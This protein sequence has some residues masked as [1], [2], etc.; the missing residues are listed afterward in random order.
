[1]AT[2]PWETFAA[3]QPEQSEP[4]AGPWSKFATPT[5]ATAGPWEQFATPEPT[6][7]SQSVWRQVADVPLHVATG[8]TQGVRMVADAFGADNPVSQ[9]LRG[10]EDYI[11]ALY[12][13][14]S[15]KD[16]KAV[17]RI[18][19]EAQDKGVGDQVKAAA[20]AFAEAPIDLLSQVLGNAAPT[21]AGGLATYL[22]RGGAAAAT[23]VGAG[24][25]A[26]MG[27]GAVK[28]S[29]YDATKQILKEQTNMSPEQ[30]EKR[31]SLA[32]A[33]DGKNLDMILAGT[34]LGGLS[35]A[36]GLEPMLARQAASRIVGTGAGKLL[37]REALVAAEKKAARE[38]AK[39]GATKQ[40]ART[41]A[42]EAGTEFAQEGQEQLAQN[43]A[44]QREGFNVPTGRGVVGAGTL[45]ALSAIGPGG[46]AGARAAQQ[47]GKQTQ[48]EGTP[49]GQRLQE[50]DALV[51]Q[52]EKQQRIAEIQ[53]KPAPTKREQTELTALQESVAATPEPTTQTQT[54]TQTQTRAPAAPA[55]DELTS[56][57]RQLAEVTAKMEQ[58]EQ[59]YGEPFEETI[60]DYMNLQA[61]VKEKSKEVETDAEREARLERAAIEAGAIDISPLEGPEAP[62]VFGP[63]PTTKMPE[64]QAPA[65]SI[66][67]PEVAKQSPFDAI[68][69]EDRARVQDNVDDYIASGFTPEESISYAL[70]DYKSDKEIEAEY[71]AEEEAKRREAEAKAQEEEYARK[72]AEQEAK[73]EK[74]RQ[75]ATANFNGALD[76]APGS[77]YNGDYDAAFEAYRQ[78]LFDTLGEE[79]MLK[80]EDHDFIVNTADREFDRLVAE[81]KAQQP[82]E[83]KPALQVVR[84]SDGTYGLNWLDKNNQ[85]AVERTFKT[86]AE[87]R[88]VAERNFAGEPVAEGVQGEPTSALEP[89]ANP[90][91]VNKQISDSGISGSNGD[92]AEHIREEWFDP[93]TGAL[94]PEYNYYAGTPSGR[95][96]TPHRDL[97]RINNLDDVAK[98]EAAGLSFFITEKPQERTADEIHSEIRALEEKQQGMLS[99]SGRMPAKGTK[100]RAEWD[101]LTDQISD[102]KGEWAE[103]TRTSAP[104]ALFAENNVVDMTERRELQLEEQETQSILEGMAA[105]RRRNDL[106]DLNDK[107]YPF[108]M[109]VTQMADKV[110][111]LE[112]IPGVMVGVPTT[113][114]LRMYEDLAYNA[115]WGV[116]GDTDPKASPFRSP[117][118][119]PLAATSVQNAM[120]ILAN[121]SADI[122]A[123][124]K[125]YMDKATRFRDTLR[126]R[127]PREKKT[128]LA[129]DAILNNV[130]PLES[131]KYSGPTG[132]NNTGIHPDVAAAIENNDINGALR[133]MAQNTSGFTREL[134]ARLAELNLP[135]NIV[136]G[137]QRT[138][139]RKEI[140]RQ[141][142]QQQVRLFMYISQVHPDLYAKYFKNFDREE[143]LEQVLEGL[144]EFNKPKYNKDAIEGE[145]RAV[146]KVF[147]DTVPNMD[148]PGFFLPAFD[149]INLNPHPY[150]GTANRVVLHEIVH[151]ATEY[152]LRSTEGLSDRQKEAVAELHAMYAYAKERI[153]TDEYGLRTI[154]EFVAELMTN[155]GFQAK[156]K[157]IPYKAQKASV[158]T[159]IVN[160]IGKIL[161]FDNLGGAAAVEVNEILSPKRREA[162]IPLGPLFAPKGPQ[163]KMWGPIS[164]PDNWR[165]AERDGETLRE[166][167]SNL[168]TNG[169]TKA[170]AITDLKDVIWDVTSDSARKLVLPFLQLRQ[171]KDMVRTKF[172][173]MEAAVGIV[174]QMIAFR[175]NKI[176]GPINGDANKSP[177]GITKRWSEAQAKAPAQSMLMGRLMIEATTRGIE[178]DPKGAKYNPNK[179][180]KALQDAWDTLTPE[181][182][183]IY[184]D[185][186]DFYARSVQDMVQAMKDKTKGLPDAERAK[187]LKQIDEQFG[188]DKLVAPYFPLRRF[189]EYW[190]QVGEGDSKEFYMFES[191]AERRRALNARRRELRG[192]TKKE[193]ALADTLYAGK[194]ISDIYSHNANTTTVLGDINKMVDN[195]T[196][197][198]PAKLKGEIKDSINQLVYLLL[199]QQSMRK[200][201]INRRSVQGA[202]ADMLRVFAMTSVHSA[203]QQARFKFAEPFL[204][205]ITNADK[206]VDEL[207]VEQQIVYRDF[208]RELEKRAQ[209]VLGVEDKSV[210]AQTVGRLTETTFFFM[211]TAPAS[212]ILNIVGMH[213]ITMP[214]IGGKYGYKETNELMLKNVGRYMAT[215]PKRTFGPLRQ[216]AF[217]QVEFPSIT[218]SKD[219]DPIERRAAD[220]FI[221]NGQLNISTTHD[222]FNMSEQPSA[223]Y[224]GRMGKLKQGLAAMFHQ[225]ERLNREVTLMSTFK[226]S[227]DQHLGAPKKDI[228]GVIERTADG[229]PVTYSEEEAFNIAIDEANDIAGLTLGDYS[230]QMKGRVFTVPGVNLLLQFKQYAITTTYAILR[231]LYLSI[232]APFT[233]SEVDQFRTE[234]QKDKDLSEK[235]IEQR[236]FEMEEQRKAMYKEGRRRLAGVLGMAF[237][238]GGITAMPFFSMLG[239]IVGMFSDDDDDDEYSNWQNTFYNG[240]ED[241]FGGAVAKMYLESGGDPQ[242]VANADA[243]GRAMAHAI[244]RGAA[245]TITGAS[246]A[247]RVSLDLKNLWFREGKFSPDARESLKEDIIANLGP[248]LGLAFN[249]TD[250]LKLIN[251]GQVQRALETIAP[252]VIGKPMTAFRLGT[253]GAT[254]KKGVVMGHMYADEFNAWELALEAMG[255]QTEERA[256][257]GKAAFQAVEYQTKVQARHDELMN[258]IWFDIKFGSDTLPDSL[259][260]A[261]EFSAKYPGKAIT[262]K[263][264]MDAVTSRSQSDAEAEALG[265]RLDKKLLYKTLPMLRD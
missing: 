47:A 192:G 65:E 153:T 182:Q 167:I 103:L 250:A 202:S 23:A 168:V 50:L 249:A 19:Q 205:N 263:D 221:Q 110:R 34:A 11:G 122:E 92:S 88:A 100:K 56:L 239:P 200:M 195:L 33:Y 209:T 84:Y 80:G 188:P 54:Q 101:A 102:K 163:N 78:N 64:E 95:F 214:Y 234:L 27:A 190:F 123:T 157:A 24:T 211:L 132:K 72:E 121:E 165:I 161:G 104:G 137:Q 179:V 203:Y 238:Y 197:A 71:A 117:E 49:E 20:L 171:M 187:L 48:F 196:T 230:R 12:S 109:R 141:T 85:P 218:E 7:E 152:A 131:V 98:A 108:L 133:A 79:G 39:R 130:V 264:V 126:T 248:A 229:K 169:P 45:G 231:N 128:K 183:Q 17:N 106:Q 42:A 1:M 67:A 74:V 62:D 138:L 164:T 154:Y 178:V 91:R 89:V 139:L 35:A 155:K 59:R 233:K 134:A 265:A 150:F 13:A 225:A 189:G 158:W 145:F 14:Q 114:A 90:E 53:Q 125:Q 148:A 227:Y 28:G 181:F 198:D 38:M 136:F 180:N 146:L 127:S 26:T 149:V 143:N 107:V 235:E 69:E 166:R 37:E 194:G 186:R 97:R 240:M 237:L 73:K 257:R 10:V 210:W 156:L 243:V 116:N 57:K 222:V 251:E 58:Q 246:I 185:A 142:A 191:A 224:T 159:R 170:D 93:K 21:I 215:A 99:K 81:H 177:E 25:G 135:T 219:L 115:Y 242:K 76:T 41:A 241:A 232:G 184:R 111:R 245:S 247:D 77:D 18:M 140:D 51:A 207:P 175:G 193:Q 112:Q 208:V 216:G 30:I 16:A 70:E 32:Q 256:M 223:M 44:Q 174:E 5:A 261:A 6:P 259:E 63:A 2:G 244:T 40:G 147:G 113:R 60:D 253:E 96:S 82:K 120:Y 83:E 129:M 255:F 262:A 15:K 55:E 236:I 258:R 75:I 212:A 124:L 31:A 173:Q 213:A 260:R 4:Q 66:A 61:Q 94:F 29:I 254:N 87:A 204:N 199:P 52:E 176:S 9:N 8:V 144:R 3:K 119:M 86:E 36:T 118:D 252:A 68:P 172:P 226:L 220:V 151:A 160:A 217:A 105:M 206:Y 22:L 228:R 43:I 46:Y 162:P 201:F